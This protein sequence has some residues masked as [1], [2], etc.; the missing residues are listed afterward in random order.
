MA[1]RHQPSIYDAMIV[2]AAI[3]GGATPLYSE[4][5]Q[6]G[7]QFGDVRVV[8]PFK[9]PPAAVNEPAAAYAVR[10]RATSPRARALGR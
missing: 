2:Q 5:L 6:D 8:D 7:Q 9:H 3:D 4:D 1:M 10:K